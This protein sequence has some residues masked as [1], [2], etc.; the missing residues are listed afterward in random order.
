MSRHRSRSLP[1]L[2]I[3]SF[4]LLVGGVACVQSDALDQDAEPHVQRDPLRAAADKLLMFSSKQPLTISRSAPVESFTFELSDR[5]AVGLGTEADASGC[6]VDTVLALYRERSHGWGPIIARSDDRDNSR[7]SHISRE[8]PKGRYRLLVKGYKRTSVGSFALSATCDGKGCPAPPTECLFGDDASQLG[9]RNDVVVSRRERILTSAQ[10][11]EDVQREQLLYA[12]RLAVPE[13]LS[14]EQAL[15][16]VD[17]DS[18]ERLWLWDAM[19]SRQFTAYQYTVD[20]AAYGAVFTQ[21]TP[22]AVA[23]IESGKLVECSVRPERCL[24]GGTYHELRESSAFERESFTVVTPSGA[25]ALSALQQEQLLSAVQ[26][27]Y[28]DATDLTSAMSS[29]DQSEINHLVLRELQSGRS[30]TVYEYGAG[31]NSYGAVFESDSPTLASQIQD[32][33]LYACRVFAQ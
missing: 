18:L 12:V 3:L 21:G 23:R 10:L 20:D 7:F 15:A 11:F 8:L 14:A 32:G 5:A 9:F 30:F 17:A 25:A 29:V 19:G 16:R 33:D 1:G 26:V 2:T 24:F 28:E 22:S 27:A 31:D 13:V 4:A 6:E